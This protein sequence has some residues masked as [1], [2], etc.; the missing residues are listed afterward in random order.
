M[1]PGRVLL[2]AAALSA[3]ASS[4]VRAQG[5]MHLLVVTGLSGEPRYAREFADAA[6]RLVDA[7]RTR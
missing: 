4:A 6:S 3:A 1:R 7:A 5:S 2:V